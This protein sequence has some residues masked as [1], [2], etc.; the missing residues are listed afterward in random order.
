[1]NWLETA[2]ILFICIFTAI[3][4][5]LAIAV[6]IDGVRSKRIPRVVSYSIAAFPFVG[7]TAIMV[8][9]AA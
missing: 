4:L 9:L 8:W 3:G 2:A 6:G 7:L 1:M 5:S